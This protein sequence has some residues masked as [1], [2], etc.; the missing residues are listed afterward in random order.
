M[1]DTRVTRRVLPPPVAPQARVWRQVLRGV[2]SLRESRVGMIGAGI[3]LA[4]ILV[5]IFAPLLAPYAPNQ[6]IKPMQPIGAIAP[7]GGTFWLGTDHLGRDILSRL[8]YGTRTVLI[9]APLATLTA[10]AMGHPDGPA[11]WL[12]ARL[13]RR[14][15][16]RAW[17]DLVLAFPA[18][19]L[20]IIIISRYGRIRHQHRAGR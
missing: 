8:I 1:S 7:G 4:W 10:Y 17:S 19:V 15:S 2:A 11:R 20:Y 5:A 18:L 13:G 12:Q 3:I 6:P 9:Y 14:D 16:C